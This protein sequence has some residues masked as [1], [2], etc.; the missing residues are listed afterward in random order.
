[1]PSALRSAP[2]PSSTVRMNEQL[3]LFSPTNKDAWFERSEPPRVFEFLLALSLIVLPWAL[4]GWMIW[5]LV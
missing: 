3:T 5:T 4:I 1:M 2:T